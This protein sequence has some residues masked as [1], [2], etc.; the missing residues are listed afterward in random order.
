MMLMLIWLRRQ[1]KLA[2]EQ[3]SETT[4][5]SSDAHDT[6]NVGDDDAAKPNRRPFTEAPMP[7]VSCL[8]C[9]YYYTLFSWLSSSWLGGVAVRGLIYR[10]S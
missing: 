7:P 5:L 8:Q 2:H 4:T 3:A 9:F 6:H 10:D 1:V